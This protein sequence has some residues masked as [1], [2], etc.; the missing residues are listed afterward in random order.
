MG[1]RFNGFNG[2]RFFDSCLNYFD[3]HYLI[4]EIPTAYDDEWR[5]GVWNGI[6]RFSRIATLFLWKSD[7]SDGR[8][9]V[10][11]RYMLYIC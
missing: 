11:Q 10:L 4:Y 2:G 1:S 7:R 3:N 8:R 9:E 6:R 5:C